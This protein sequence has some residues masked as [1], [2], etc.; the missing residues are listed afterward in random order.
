MY[1][2]NVFNCPILSFCGANFHSELIWDENYYPTSPYSS[3]LS[4]LVIPSY[5]I[6]FL[7]IY[8]YISHTKI[9]NGSNLEKQ[10]IELCHQKPEFHFEPIEIQLAELNTAIEQKYGLG[11]SLKT[12][13]F[14]V[15]KHSNLSEIHFVFHL[16]TEKNAGLFCIKFFLIKI[17]LEELTNL[18][19]PGLK[20]ILLLSSHY[21]VSC[22]TLPLLL[23][24]D[25]YV[26][27]FSDIAIQKHILSM[28][29]LVKTFLLEN[30]KQ[31]HNSLKTIQFV[32]NTPESYSQKILN[33]TLD[34]VKSLFGGH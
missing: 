21:D 28:A 15:T 7:L 30:T 9:L 6:N 19:I 12:G 29:K 20:N 32:V 23:I 27:Q 25:E 10:L 26:F 33:D 22:I 13:D 24:Q 18:L 16:A 34:K 31:Q 2:I 1:T 3:N 5:N 11:S 4:A 17:D 14:I 8:L